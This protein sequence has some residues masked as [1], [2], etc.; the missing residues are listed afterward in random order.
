MQLWA[1]YVQSCSIQL[2]CCCPVA[3]YWTALWCWATWE[4]WVRTWCQTMLLLVWA[5]SVQPRHSRLSWVSRWLLPS[6]VCRS[7]YWIV[8]L[9]LYFL[10]L[11]HVSLIS[12]V[13]D[14]C[15]DFMQIL[16]NFVWIPWWAFCLLFGQLCFLSAFEYHGELFVHF[17]FEYQITT[18][19]WWYNVILIKWMDIIQHAED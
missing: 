5:C 12:C 17:Y 10:G 7:L 11:Q 16:V 19:L 14:C 3:M 6:E 18:I 2:R 13:L 1:V 8:S 9:D 4:Q 15:E